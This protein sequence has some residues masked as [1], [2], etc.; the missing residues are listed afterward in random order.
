LLEPHSFNTHRTKS[1]TIHHQ[2]QKYSCTTRASTS[3]RR[4]PTTVKSRRPLTSAPSPSWPAPWLRSGRCVFSA[5]WL[6]AWLQAAVPR[7]S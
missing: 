6:G 5:A 7:L 3:P 1:Q 2:T 4:I